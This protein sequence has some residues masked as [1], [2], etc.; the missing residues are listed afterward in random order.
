[1]AS[2]GM[3]KSIQDSISACLVDTTRTAG[4]IAGEDLAFQRSSNP[5]IGPLLDTQNT[6]LLNIA[7]VLIESAVAGTGISP[8]ELPNAEAVD[9]GWR[10]IV[11]VV[12]NLLERAD[13]CLDEYTGVIKRT[14]PTQK[15]TS[16]YTPLLRK[17]KPAKAYQDQNI[18]KPQL[19]FNTIPTNNETAPFIPLLRTKP[20]AIVPLEQSL[21]LFIPEDGLKEYDTHFYLSMRECPRPFKE[22]I[23]T[24]FRYKHPYETE[25]NQARYPPSTYLKVDPIPFLPFESTTATYV[26]TPEA[27]LAMLAELKT[28]KEIAVDLEHHDTHSYIGLVSLMQISTREKDWVIDTL[29]PW[30]EDLQVLNEVFTDP[31]ILKVSI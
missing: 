24:L 8:P 4:Q 14:N 18:P 5:S 16:K 26:D 25:I 28:A 27:M 23:N 11:D 21:D 17:Q 9:D 31:Q 3:F 22:L 20:N 6:R 15:D 13:A 12:D 29:K 10:G 2:D 7:R 30:R 1:M 19:L